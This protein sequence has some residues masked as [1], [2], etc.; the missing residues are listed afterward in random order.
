LPEPP[1]RSEPNWAYKSIKRNL[2]EAGLRLHSW[3]DFDVQECIPDPW[4]LY[5]GLTWYCMEDEVPP[6]QEIAPDLER[7]LRNSPDH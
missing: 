5:V 1:Y 6:Y 3:W 2:A 7:I 4:E